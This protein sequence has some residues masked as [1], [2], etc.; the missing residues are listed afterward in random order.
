MPANPAGERSPRQRLLARLHVAS[1]LAALTAIS[2]GLVVLCGG[3][4]GNVWFLRTI[5]PGAASMKANTALGLILLGAAL[6]L[7][8]RRASNQ[9][10]RTLAFIPAVIA[11]ILGALTTLEYVLRRNLYIDELLVRDYFST[12]AGDPPGRMA[13][14]T[15]ISF[16]LLGC[17]LL[18]TKRRRGVRVS[19][20][21]AFVLACVW[22][23]SLIGYLFGIQNFR[24]I[25]F[26]TTVAIHTSLTLFIL[27][28]GV[29]C[30]NANAGLMATVTSEQLG[31]VLARS[32]LPAAVLV[33]TTLGWLTW[34]GE[35]RGYYGHPFAMSI[36][37][38]ASV[39]IFVLLIWLHGELLNRLDRERQQSYQRA[40]D[41]E[42]NF[43]QLADSMPQIVYTA[44]TDGWLDYCNQRWL[45]Y[46][47]LTLTQSQGWGSLAAI[48]PDD[49]QDVMD[50]WDRTISTG[51]SYEIQ[52]RLKRASDG[53]YRW[54]LGRGLP[55]R[56]SQG[57]IIKWFGTSTDI[58]D[59]KHAQQALEESQQQLEARVQE[60][61]VELERSNNLLHAIL[62]SMGDGVI[63][64]NE[65]YEHILFNRAARKLLRS[66]PEG[67]T[68]E[69]RAETFGIYHPDKKTLFNRD[70]LPLGRALR[71]ESCD[72]VEIFGPHPE[73]EEGRW[74]S[75]NS[76][77]MKDSSDKVY[78]A[79][80][81]MHDI[82]E[83]RRLEE[84]KA[85]LLALL[86]ETSDF[87]GTARPDGT[88][89]YANRALRRLRGLSEG[90]SIEGLRVGGVY[91][92]SVTKQM[93]ADAMQTAIQFG[94]WRGENVF[95]Y[96]SGEEI[97]VSQLIMSHRNSDG[98]LE[99]MSTIAR[100][101]S[102]IKDKESQLQLVRQ[103]LEAT[104]EKE[105]ELARQDPLTGLANRRA[106]LETCEI[107]KE[108]SRRYHHCFNIAYL[109]LDSFK[110]VNDQLGHAIGDQVLAQV[111]CTLRSNLRSTDVVA[112]LGGDEFAVL[113]TETDPASAEKVL[114]KLH[115]LL[116][117]AMKSRGWNVDFSIGLASYRC[118]PESID[119]IIRAADGLMY[120][121]KAQGKGNV[122]VA[123]LS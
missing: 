34:H 93:M 101:I 45:D 53:A 23:V 59:Y 6:W 26:Y 74:L 83:R 97:P 103:Q 106:F 123:L 87:V 80:L 82:T 116:R 60:R 14:T 86:E 65:K 7:D 77:P 17:A 108:R 72:N 41:S 98:E 19:Q 109:D 29:L 89:L 81:V 57:T 54:H 32:L 85:R 110:A 107:E 94:A 25:A 5:L 31:G 35:L 8:G 120:S 22:L 47:G 43:R 36:A 16:G 21:L 38:S 105:S 118:P 121:V 96:H 11:T 69:R 52:F 62:E 122:A 56:D 2:V 49:T 78:G 1:V 13:V 50:V 115:E 28:L 113:L 91:A 99:F 92:P 67:T 70:Q 3:W 68:P 30:A 55:M 63:C 27:C 84:Y 9:G 95:R 102:E 10:G 111:A 46:T 104:L 88:I 61:T 66:A 90:E 4:F 42:A 112:R 64:I 44:R 117:V 79:V 24:G 20:S 58:D 33:P 18:L 39:A 51:I 114:R 76:R 15:A 119:T 71:G 37:T 48:H 73:H 75:C 100:D 12:T 40:I